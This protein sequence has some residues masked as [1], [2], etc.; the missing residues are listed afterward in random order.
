MIKQNKKKMNRGTE[1]MNNT[2]RKAESRKEIKNTWSKLEK[3]N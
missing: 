2:S 1:K 3:I